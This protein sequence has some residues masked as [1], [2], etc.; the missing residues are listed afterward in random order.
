MMKRVLVTGAAGF[1]GAH[2]VRLLLDGGN[3]VVAATRPG[4]NHWRLRDVADQIELVQIDLLQVANSLS[5][6]GVRPDAVIN[7]AA[8]GVEYGLCDCTLALQ[9]NAIGVH[10]LMHAAAGSEIG[11]FIH[12]GSCFEYGDKNHPI[13]EDA[14]L[15]PTNFYGVTKAAASLIV[16]QHGRELGLPA[17]I[18]RPFGMWGPFESL[19]RLVPQIVKASLDNKPLKLTD[20]E[21]VRDYTY[22]TDTAAA[23]VHLVNCA[24]FPGGEIFNLGS[25]QPL[26]VRDFVTAC[27]RILGAEEIMSFGTLSYRP[28]EMWSLVADMSKWEQFAEPVAKTGLEESLPVMADEVKMRTERVEPS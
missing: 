21:Q 2:V 8:Y 17:V 10:A 1:L 12:I 27:A 16:R 26:K 19:H 5:D 24:D 28:D 14:A 3:E 18:V 13:G 15:D 20:G 4:T 23:I 25:G 7:C 22:V 6:Y 9:T 11:R